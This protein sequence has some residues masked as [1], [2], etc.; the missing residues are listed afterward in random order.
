M[1]KFKEQISVILFKLLLIKDL[2]NTFKYQSKLDFTSRVLMESHRLEKSMA[3]SYQAKGRG[4]DKAL[5]LFNYI[6]MS[7][8]YKKDEKYQ[9]ALEL[10]ASTIYSFI[11]HKE[12]IDINELKLKQLKKLFEESEIKK[13]VNNS[14]GGI[15]ETSKPEIQFDNTYKLFHSRHSCRSFD[16]SPLNME[17]FTRAIDLA[18]QSPSAC[19]RQPTRLYLISDD[20]IAKATGRSC[21]NDYD[22]PYHLIVTVDYSAY[23]LQEYNDWIV[24][25][26]IFTGYLTLALHSVQIASCLMRKPLYEHSI[27]TKAYRK[28]CGIPDNEKIIIE[29]YIGNYPQKFYVPISKRLTSNHILKIVEN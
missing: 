1:R 19:N 26:S 14:F 17:N 23:E 7:D 24:S 2:L 9:F 25:S 10:A 4:Y 12:K 5:W 20:R 3:Q 18:M 8:N 13:L 27:I 15:Y 16:S 11:K 22:A 29:M 6:K 21:N 28:E